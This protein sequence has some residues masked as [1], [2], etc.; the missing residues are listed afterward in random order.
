[1]VEKKKVEIR[2]A[3]QDQVTRYRLKLHLV[4]RTPGTLEQ[5]SEPILCPGARLLPA[6]CICTLK[7]RCHREMEALVFVGLWTLSH[8][9]VTPLYSAAVMWTF[10]EGGWRPIIIF[11]E[12][13]SGF[14]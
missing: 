11:R 3:G 1:M 13:L 10:Q 12:I 7:H 9:L 6:P 2:K 5:P 14:L 8:F 4:V